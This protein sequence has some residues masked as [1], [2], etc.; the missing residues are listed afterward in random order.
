MRAG[1]IPKKGKACA[2][3]DFQLQWLRAVQERC[4]HASVEKTVR[5]ICDFYRKLTSSDAAAE[6]E[7]FLRRRGK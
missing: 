2:V 3:F 4:A 5:I 1:H 7:L 6:A